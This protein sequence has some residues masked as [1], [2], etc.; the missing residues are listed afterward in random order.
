MEA[1]TK[2]LKGWAVTVKLSLRPCY[3]TR[4]NNFPDTVEQSRT[5]PLWHN[6][7]LNQDAIESEVV[8]FVPIHTRVQ[9]YVRLKRKPANCVYSR[10]IVSL[11][12][13]G[14]PACVRGRTNNKNAFRKR[15]AANSAG[16]IKAYSV[17]IAVNK[18]NRKLLTY[19]W[20]CRT[21]FGNQHRCKRLLKNDLNTYSLK[22]RV[23][24][25]I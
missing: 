12:D 4:W 8:D 15:L 19:N 14:L 22:Y 16:L 21:W 13:L 3:S 18:A 20:S 17:T 2:E 1:S 9:Y 6:A 10:Q 11:T 5:T 25:L 23:V 24:M 7:P